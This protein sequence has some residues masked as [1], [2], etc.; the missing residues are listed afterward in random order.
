MQLKSNQEIDAAIEK[1]RSK[2]TPERSRVIAETVRATRPEKMDELDAI[3]SEHLSDE[4]KAFYH[5]IVDRSGDG[6]ALPGASS[7]EVVNDHSEQ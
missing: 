6:L 1:H 2:V 4:E 7:T 3:F 5:D